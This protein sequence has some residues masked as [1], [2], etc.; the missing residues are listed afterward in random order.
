MAMPVMLSRGRIFLYKID[1][2]GFLR[3]EKNIQYE[4]ALMALT[5]LDNLSIAMWVGGV[6]LLGIGFSSKNLGIGQTLMGANFSI[7]ALVQ[8]SILFKIL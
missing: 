8:S 7:F 1:T 2:L 5:F 6:S 3:P 4:E